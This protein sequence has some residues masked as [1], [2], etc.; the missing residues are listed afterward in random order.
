MDLYDITR[1]L[2]EGIVV[3][4]GDP[5]LQYRWV[6]RIAEGARCNISSVY[7]GV[8]TGTHID[9]P[10]HLS[11]F[12]SDISG[13]PI[14]PMMGPVRVLSISNPER[15]GASDLEA[16]DWFGVERVLFKTRAEGPMECVFDKNYTYL[17]ESASEF[18][19]KLRILLVG[20][21]AP[22]VD[23][24]DSVDYRSHQILL[25]GGTV[26]LE[27]AE[28]SEVP[29]G[30]YELICLPLKFAGLDGSPVRAVLRKPPKSL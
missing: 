26:I 13:V 8:H 5:H 18:L 29:D 25:R 21:D 10:L 17:D 22:S 20:T 27:N 16:L 1:T 12:G 2:H 3:W 11:D 14:H 9:A 28:L 19:V 24:F 6:S 30:D 4:P 15:I 7:M 23:A